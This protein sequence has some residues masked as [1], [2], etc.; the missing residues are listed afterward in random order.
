MATYDRIGPYINSILSVKPFIKKG[1]DISLHI[2]VDTK[3]SK[4]TYLL[5]KCITKLI[6][7][8]SQYTFSRGKDCVGK[9]RDLLIRKYESDYFMN[10]D[11]DD[12]ISSIGFEKITE[13]V[14]SLDSHTSKFT[15]FNFDFYPVAK[16]SKV[17]NFTKFNWIP[18][19]WFSVDKGM[20]AIGQNS[21]FS[22]ELYLSISKKYNYFRECVDDMLPN[23]VMYL[24]A[25]EIIKLSNTK[26]IE[27][28]RGDKSLMLRSD[29]TKYSDIVFS[30]KDFH[31][32]LDKL[33]ADKEFKDMVWKVTLSN[34]LEYH[35]SKSGID[36]SYL[37]NMC[38]TGYS[39]YKED[40]D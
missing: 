33:D 6:L 4:S 40:Y 31:E 38:F 5:K 3:L 2:G 12:L 24:T 34:Q 25:D 1:S 14:R 32:F 13:L 22:R 27:R 26:V 28:K 20:P 7:G 16:F 18:Q 9:T 8:D 15:I 11:D 29:M 23:H 17:S 10:L 39:K 21:I 35:G 36:F 19:D 30:L 37:I